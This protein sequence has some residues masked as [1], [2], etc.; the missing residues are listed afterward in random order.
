MLDQEQEEAY[1]SVTMGDDEDDSMGVG[2]SVPSKQPTAT[3][4]RF[5]SLLVFVL[6]LA[7]SS[8][9]LS[10]RTD[11]RS[12]ARAQGVRYQVHARGSCVHR[13][14]DD[15]DQDACLVSHAL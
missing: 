12:F 1:Q 11:A 10:V 6:V 13:L 4:A 2:A 5:V 9:C 14:L 3:V 8:V 15:Q 7:C